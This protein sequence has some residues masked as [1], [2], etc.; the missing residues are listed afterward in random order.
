MHTDCEEELINLVAV[1]QAMEK[2]IQ[3]TDYVYL[4]LILQTRILIGICFLVCN[5]NKPKEVFL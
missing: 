3:N 5:E 4:F 2:Q 1:A